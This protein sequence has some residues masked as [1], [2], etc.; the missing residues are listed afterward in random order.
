MRTCMALAPH[1]IMQSK[2]Y[3]PVRCWDAAVPGQIGMLKGLVKHRCARQRICSPDPQP[4]LKL[5]GWSNG[6]ETPEQKKDARQSFQYDTA[7]P[8]RWREQPHT[9]HVFS[10]DLLLVLRKPDPDIQRPQTLL[11]S[12]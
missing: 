8:V 12:P 1:M 6:F 10:V 3:G 2:A 7:A 5:T 11:C 9:V 4:P